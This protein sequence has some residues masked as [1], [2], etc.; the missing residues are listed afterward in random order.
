MSRRFFVLLS[1]F[2]ISSDKSQKL[3]IKKI[4]I[5]KMNKNAFCPVSNKKVDERVARFNAMFTVFVL[6]A[7]GFTFNIFLILFLAADFLLR[8][9]EYSKYSPIVISSKFM[10]ALFDAD[11]NL[12]NAGPKIFA[13]RIGVTLGAFIMLALLFNVHWLVIGLAGILGLFSFLEFA[14]GICVACIIYP[15]V[16]QIVYRK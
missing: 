2:L 9:L 16:Y 5:Y 4:R 15:Y 13:A 8:A 10:L 11:P 14:F 6:I 12:I 7:F 1:G 3:N